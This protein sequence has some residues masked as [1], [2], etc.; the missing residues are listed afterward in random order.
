MIKKR[1]W[2]FI[3]YPESLPNNWKDIIAQTGLPFAI[4]PLH[5]KDL[6]KD[7]NLKKPHYHVILCYDG[8]TTYKNVCSLVCEQLGQPRPQVVESVRGYYHYFTHI[9]ELDKATYNEEDIQTFNCFDE[10]D[11]LTSGEVLSY[12][13]QIQV[14]INENG[15]VEYSDLLDFLLDHDFDLWKVASNHT[16]FLN[17]YL[18]SLRHRSTISLDNKKLT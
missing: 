2:S 5:D 8:P 9:D 15:F 10:L 18:T 3:G 7:G 14:I 1:N 17:T 16:I 13:K 4:S 11:L 12:L 6:D